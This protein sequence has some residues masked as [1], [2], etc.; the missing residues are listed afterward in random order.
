MVKPQ[1]ASADGSCRVASVPR[2]LFLERRF[3]SPL[4]ENFPKGT[5][6]TL[7]PWDPQEIWPLVS[8]ALAKTTEVEARCTLI[9]LF[10]TCGGGKALDAV[11]AARND[12]EARVR[13]A[14]GVRP[15]DQ[16]N[17]VAADRNP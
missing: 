4:Q 6:I 5:A 7:T 16:E 1:R 13:E 15:G 12:P 2:A 17:R 9:G 10:P 3:D 8:A 11:K 14:A